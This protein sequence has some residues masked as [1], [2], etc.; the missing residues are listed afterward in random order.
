MSHHP[1]RYAWGALAGLGA[2]ALMLIGGVAT[3]VLASGREALPQ[4]LMN[5]CMLFLGETGGWAWGFITGR[6]LATLAAGLILASFGWAALRL[7]ASLLANL[8]VAQALARVAPGQAPELERALARAPRVPRG[9]IRVL[10][11]ERAEA[12]TVGSWRPRICLTTGLMERLSEDELAAVLLHEAAH[13]RARDPLRLALGRFLADALWFVPL[14]RTLRETF[15]RMAELG[16]DQA[17]MAAGG[18]AVELASAIVKTAQ[19][20]V[21]PAPAISPALDGSSFL[22]ERVERLLG[23]RR[24]VPLELSWRQTLASG[25]VV[26]A[27]LVLLLS[28]GASSGPA[29]EPRAM[30]GTGPMMTMPMMPGCEPVMCQAMRGRPF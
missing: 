10:S 20:R 5:A 28:G 14:A 23:L 27:L 11:T 7:G 17:A 16:A 24:V 26:A 2:L 1:H 19:G 13:L 21:G 4:R 8:R 25:G 22:E 3:A 30:R 29:M 6:P 12:F 18:E 9:R 15:A